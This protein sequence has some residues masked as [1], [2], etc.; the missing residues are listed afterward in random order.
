M[1]FIYEMTIT[2]QVSF[3]IIHYN[4]DEDALG[5]SLLF[6][7]ISL[8]EKSVSLYIFLLKVSQS[9]DYVK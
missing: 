8:G 3:N 1:P 4:A 5:I 6:I 7:S 9:I 2:Q